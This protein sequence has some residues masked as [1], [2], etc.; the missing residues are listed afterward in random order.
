MKK[1]TIIKITLACMIL[2]G[3]YACEKGATT[4]PE[5]KITKKIA[6]IRDYNILEAE[7]E[8]DG[9]ALDGLD[10]ERSRITFDKCGNMAAR[11]NCRLFWK[12]MELEIN[13]RCF[14]VAGT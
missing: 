8:Y 12:D 9:V 14:S 11:M 13:I 7:G 6:L 2:C 1:A 10:S 3:C 4:G 5:P